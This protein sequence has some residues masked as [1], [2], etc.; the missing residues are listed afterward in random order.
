MWTLFAVKSLRGSSMETARILVSSFQGMV[1]GRG[2]L[3]KLEH[4]TVEIAQESLDNKWAERPNT[5]WYPIW[6][7]G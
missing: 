3:V 4:K 5:M 2:N 6:A 7:W 1:K